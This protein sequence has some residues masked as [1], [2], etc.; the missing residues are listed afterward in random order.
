MYVLMSSFYLQQEIASILCIKYIKINDGF[1][2]LRW[3]YIHCQ[4]ALVAS[5]LIVVETKV[6]KSSWI[7]RNKYTWVRNNYTVLRVT[8]H[9]KR[10]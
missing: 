1:Y 4:P 8:G 6:I 2:R 5:I 7:K 3:G 9:T 10:L